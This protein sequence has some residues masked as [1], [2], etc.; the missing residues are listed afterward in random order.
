[1]PQT[2]AT[3]HQV[4]ETPSQRRRSSMSAVPSSTQDQ[5]LYTCVSA[6]NPATIAD[7]TVAMKSIDALLPNNDGLK[8]FNRLYLMVTDQVNA[9]PPGGSWQSPAWL[10]HLDV[11]FAGFYF[12]ALADF[13][14]G[15]DTPA[16]WMAV[17]EARFKP[18]I[19]RIQF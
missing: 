1:M 15:V 16:A 14:A 11:V 4:F 12:K 19:D 3:P 2:S 9:N 5:Q 18:G 17:F 13:L 8:W 6:A 10:E 7:V